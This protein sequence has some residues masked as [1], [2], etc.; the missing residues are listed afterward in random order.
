M[1]R[2]IDA[3][4]LIETNRALWEHAQMNGMYN[5]A[6]IYERFV[7]S[8]EETSTAD[9]VPRSEVEKLEKESSAFAEI[10]HKQEDEIQQLRKSL[11][12]KQAL[13]EEFSKSVKKIE[14][15]ALKTIEKAKQEVAREIFK[16]IEKLAY[17]FMNDNHYIFPDMVWDIAELKKKY[18]E[19]EDKE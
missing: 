14:K 5:H 1:A 7:R 6:R 11:L 18:T 16:E 4:K 2:Y 13:E 3:D 8:I 9:V 15:Q 19:S 12:T 10:I 17:R